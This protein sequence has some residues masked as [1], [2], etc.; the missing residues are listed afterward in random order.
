MDIIE[1]IGLFIFLGWVL[2][3]FI[4]TESCQLSIFLPGFQKIPKLL[5]KL[6]KIE[7][8]G[9][10]TWGDL[11][12]TEEKRLMKYNDKLMSV[13]YIWLTFLYNQNLIHL[14]LP[15]ENRSF[16]IPIDKHQKE[17]IHE[18]I[19]S[20]DED[21]DVEFVVYRQTKS[22][23]RSPVLIGYLK[24]GKK[25][26]LETEE[27]EIEILF[28]FPETLVKRKFFTKVLENKYKLKKN[29]FTESIKDDLG[30]YG[31]INHISYD[32]E[33]KNGGLFNFQTE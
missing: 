24:K 6:A 9:E 28:E 18:N 30:H 1:I 4:K 23:F 2:P 5:L 17:L 10:V 29:T 8:D 16:F 11:D 22:W 19:G 7:K 32:Q 12:K 26:L 27:K 15:T 31:W 3:L 20:L 13:S 33:H 21:I 25:I 14:Q